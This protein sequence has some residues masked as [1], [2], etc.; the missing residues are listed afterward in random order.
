MDFNLYRFLASGNSFN[1]L[2]NRFHLEVSTV[3]CIVKR[4]C[5][6][7][8]EKLHETEMKPS[9]EAEWKDISHQFWRRWN[10]PNCIGA[11]DGKH[12]VMQP[13]PNS[14]SLFFNYEGTF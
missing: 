8:W 7:R 14:G 4:T 6:I 9:K 5:N 10:F 12:I 11:L 2:A 13:P 1:A 3:H